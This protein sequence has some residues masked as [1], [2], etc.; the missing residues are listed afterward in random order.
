LIGALNVAGVPQAVGEL[1][2]RR[3]EN[4]EFPYTDNYF[5]IEFFALD[6]APN[7]TSR[8]QYKLEGTA[9]EWSKPTEDR[10]VDFAN[11]APG[12]YHF[13]VRAVNDAGAA[14]E[15][16]AAIVFK[17]NPPFWRTWWFLTLAAVLAIAAVHSLYRYR[18]KNLRRV[19]QALIETQIAEEKVL[20]ERG[21]RLAELDRVR[22]RI[23]TDL[24]DDIGSSLT[25]IAVLSE[26]A[27]NHAV[28]LRSE[29]VSTS[30]E[31]IKDVSRE[32]AETMSDVVWA[33]S[34]N[35]DN[36]GDLVQRMRRFGSDVGAGSDINFELDASPAEKIVPLGANVRREVFAIFKESINNAVK[37]SECENIA[38]DFRIKNNTLFLEVKDDGHGFDTEEIL[39]DGFSPEKGGNGLI[40]MRR[41]A[42]G[43]GG[44]CRIVSNSGGTGVFL[45]VPLNLPED[46]PLSP[47]QSG[48]A[49]Q[50]EVVYDESYDE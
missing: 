40:N 17:I 35:K 45:E 6:F 37:Y 44:T 20:R 18:M 3:L 13:L 16:P 25:Q 2:S 31:S 23:A 48:G 46:E 41:R 49:I 30:L 14:S 8:Y 47:A 12:E 32:L 39:S 26:V 24:H 43:L 28:A 9:A 21:K 7:E 10:T 19:N 11:L 27:R 50:T 29:I 22:T 42:A 1:G 5:Q 36:L 38:A 33:I 15:D 4:L 34:P